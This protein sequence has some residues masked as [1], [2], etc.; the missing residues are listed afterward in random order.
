MVSLL[1]FIK[2]PFTTNKSTNEPVF[3]AEERRTGQGIQKT[4]ADEMLE[5]EIERLQEY[6]PKKELKNIITKKDAE[7][8]I[9]K[10]G[11]AN[12][13]ANALTPIPKKASKKSIKKAAKQLQK[14]WLK[15]NL[16]EMIKFKNDRVI[17]GL[18]AGPDTI[19]KLVEYTR[20]DGKLVSYPQARSLSSGK[21]VALSKALRRIK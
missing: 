19:I 17:K 12:D 21:I 3:R 13:P 14:I 15:K 16:N 1:D 10:L 18:K 8:A 9:K 4:T 20:K 6:I 5:T 11:E 2:K 7:E